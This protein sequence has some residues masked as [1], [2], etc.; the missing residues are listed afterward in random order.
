MS[1][2]LNRLVRTVL[3][4]YLALCSGEQRRWILAF[5][6]RWE[7]QAVVA[8]MACSMLVGRQ[9]E[10]KDH[11]PGLCLDQILSRALSTVYDLLRPRISDGSVIRLVLSVYLMAFR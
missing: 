4:L 9:V 5:S 7:K 11:L 6:A 1:V 10:K 8:P 3:V 2:I